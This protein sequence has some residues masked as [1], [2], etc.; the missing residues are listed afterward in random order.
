MKAAIILAMAGL[1]TACAPERPRSFLVDGHLMMAGP[2]SA[3]NVWVGMPDPASPQILTP[4]DNNIH[5]RSIKAIE[6]ASGCK[7]IPESIAH[8]T[9]TMTTAVVKC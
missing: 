6:H 2:Q 8:P 4:G 7:V 5:L 9:W 3:P 1:L